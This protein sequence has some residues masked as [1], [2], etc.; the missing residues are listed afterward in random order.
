MIELLHYNK[1]LEGEVSGTLQLSFRSL[2]SHLGLVG[3]CGR[4]SRLILHEIVC[5][6]PFLSFV[7]SSRLGMSLFLWVL[8]NENRLDC[9]GYRKRKRENWR[10]G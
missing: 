9:R 1:D 4:E 10:N 8:D 2:T 7:D 6:F 5:S 3:P